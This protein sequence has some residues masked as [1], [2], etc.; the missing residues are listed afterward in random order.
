[1]RQPAVQLEGQPAPAP[2]PWYVI[3]GSQKFGILVLLGGLLYLRLR[4]RQKSRLRIC[5]HC[6]QKNPHHLAHCTKCSAPLFQG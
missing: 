2:R 4:R 5:S 1:M 6:G 3:T